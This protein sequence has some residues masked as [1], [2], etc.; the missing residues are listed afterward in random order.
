M[1]DTLMDEGILRL[2]E[3]MEGVIDCRAYTF[4]DSRQGDDEA[5][6][7]LNPHPLYSSYSNVFPILMYPHFFL[8]YLPRS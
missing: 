4:V 2:I 3:G 8:I 7:G 5:Q 6:R 1:V